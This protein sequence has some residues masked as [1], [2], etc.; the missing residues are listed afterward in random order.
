MHRFA[1]AFITIWLL[2]LPALTD[3][4][5]IENAWVRATTP[6]QKVAGGFMGC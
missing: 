3:T 4:V 5:K 2:A 6:G 1:L